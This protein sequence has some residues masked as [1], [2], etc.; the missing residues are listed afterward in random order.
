MRAN[1]LLLLLLL[2]LGFN[3]QEIKLPKTE[4]SI[5]SNKGKMYI[6][7]GWNR[8]W[9]SNSDIH[10]TGENY[11]FTLD[12]VEAK[13]RQS[14]FNFGTYFKPSS[15]T[16]PQTNFRIGYFINDKYDISIG[17]DHM[18]YVMVQNQITQI[19]GEI[20]DSTNYDGTYSDNNI[21]LTQDFLIYEHTDGLNY[22][23]AEITRNDDLLDLLKVN[24]NSDKIQINTLLG[25]GLG[26][27]MPKS[28]VTL[29]NNKRHDEFHFAGYGFSAKAGINVTFFKHFFIRTEYKAGFI[30]MPD[31]RTSPDPS[32]K[33]AQHFTFTQWNFD[34]GVSFKLFK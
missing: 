28:N 5:K 33:A 18:K 12:N 21:A 34:F 19:T 26:A 4:T 9:Y 27:L 22:L 17:V 11:D 20:N 2:S 8:G 10:F 6:F 24:L 1:F 13:D 23:N 7:W 29:W 31:I 30:N 15:I 25:V 14:P 32:D 16:I 3:A